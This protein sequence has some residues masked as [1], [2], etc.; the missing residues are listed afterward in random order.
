MRS[1]PAMLLAAAMA[2]TLTGCA[3]LG[4]SSPPEPSAPAPDPCPASIMAPVTDEPLAPEGVMIADL[5]PGLAA[6]WFGEFIPWAREH[7]QRLV[8]AQA[9]CSAR[10]Q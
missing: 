8:R 10:A 5:P 2:L 1:M 3:T 6:W 9:W 4:R 7:P